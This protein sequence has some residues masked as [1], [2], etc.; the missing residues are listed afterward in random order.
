MFANGMDRLLPPQGVVRAS[1]VKEDQVATIGLR[2]EAESG[3][4]VATV[5]GV[6]HV[7]ATTTPIEDI[8]GDGGGGI[9]DGKSRPAYARPIFRFSSK[10]CA[11]NAVEGVLSHQLC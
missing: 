1:A 6:R 4:A 5:V 2:R 3:A 8:D 10:P 11:G 9:A 7:A